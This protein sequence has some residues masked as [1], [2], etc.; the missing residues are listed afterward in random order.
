MAE[1]PSKLEETQKVLE[2][3]QNFDVASIARQEDLGKELNFQDAVEPASKLV[4]LFKRLSLRVLPD[5]PE[6]M[7]TTINQQCSANLEKL[8]APLAFSTAESNPSSRRNQLIQQIKDAYDSAFKNLLPFIGYANFQAID[9]KR[10]EDEALAITRSMKNESNRISEQSKA[11]LQEANEALQTVRELAAEQGV[12]QQA[13]YFKSEAEYH[14]AQA[15]QWKTQ[16]YIFAIGTGFYALASLFFHKIPWFSP[17]NNYEVAQF[18]VS[19]VLIF[20]ILS[21]ML[22]MAVR[23]FMSHTHNAVVNK[24]RQNALLTYKSFVD[25]TGD[26]QGSEAVLLSAA[27]CIYSPQCTGYTSDSNGNING[28]RNI[29]ELFSKSMTDTNS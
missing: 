8:N 9:F 16:I 13:E 21:Y 17:Q 28:G 24:H 25:A 29:V 23:N 19:K 5:L 22:Y 2:E 15:E 4:S 7:L 26:L 3:I 1:T 6:S 20:G 27:S 10:L 11:T 18:I 14:L 12:T